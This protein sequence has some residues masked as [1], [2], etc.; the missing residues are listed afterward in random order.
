CTNDLGKTHSITDKSDDILKF[1]IVDFAAELSEWRTALFNND[2]VKARLYI[3]TILLKLCQFGCADILLIPAPNLT[4]TIYQWVINEPQRNWQSRDLEIQLGLSGAT[5]R[6]KLN[7]EGTTL[8]ET[9]T[10]ARLGYAI[11]LLY[12]THLPLKTVAA[13]SGYQSVAVFKE[14]FLQRYGFDP[15]VL[16]SGWCQCEGLY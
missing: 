11:N 12:S 7:A 4:K 14:R 1:S 10:H 13:K 16:C 5:L 6:R 8:R 2:W 9:I 15:N 3:T